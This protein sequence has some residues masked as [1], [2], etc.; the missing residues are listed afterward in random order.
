VTRKT[1]KVW[2]R[3]GHS[4]LIPGPLSGY[5]LRCLNRLKEEPMFRNLALVG[6]FGV[7]LLGCRDELTQAPVDLS[8]PF[9]GDMAV[10]ANSDLSMTQMMTAT[11]AHDIDTGA[12]AAG[13]AVRLSGM[14]SV[15]NIHRHLSGTTMYCEYRT[16]VTD[17][18][19]T[20]AP[21]GIELYERGVKL[22][23]PGATTTDCPSPYASGSTLLVSKI[24]NY[25]DVMDISGSTKTFVDSTA[26]MLVNTHS[27]TVDTLTIT[28]MK[29]PL[30][31]PIDVTDTATSMFTPHSGAG[32]NM[33]EGTYIKL[34]PA[35]GK[36]SIAMQD[37]YGFTTNNGAQFSTGDYFGPK[38]GGMF[39]PSGATYSSLSGVVWND[40]GGQVTPLLPGDYVP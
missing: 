3:S 21:C 37:M 35:S 5:E 25:G 2:A 26:P 17:G 39:P 23:T 20:S 32:Y 8:R 36:F 33:Y 27:L 11:S 18:S 14:I 22:T 13:T 29:G 16:F 40:F 19:C 10:N 34:T 31:T 4:A 6:M 12:V 30:P 7:G 28:T 15:D 9:T 38:D 1:L 24:Q